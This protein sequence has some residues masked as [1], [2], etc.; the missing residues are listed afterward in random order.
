MIEYLE[1]HIFKERYPL[2]KYINGGGQANVYA[3][4]EKYAVKQ[5]HL[6]GILELL[7]ELN[8]SVLLDHPCILKPFAWTFDIR[9]YIAMPL[10][11]DI[12]QAYRDKLISIEEIVSDTLSAITYIFK[13]KIVHYDIKT[14]NILYHEGKATII[15]MGLSTVCKVE[16]RIQRDIFA[17]ARCYYEL[18]TSDYR[19]SKFETGITHVDWFLDKAYMDKPLEEILASI[20]KQLIVRRY[21]GK[22]PSQKIVTKIYHFTDKFNLKSITVNLIE[23]L[24]SRCIRENIDMKLL[25]AMCI[26]IATTIHEDVQFA[27]TQLIDKDVTLNDC[28]QMI[29]DIMRICECKILILPS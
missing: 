25:E 4:G 12:T 9:G 26:K 22:I 1:P 14:S 27:Y 15:D 28:Y 11:Q 10:G 2:G 5:F 17:L 21:T 19:L 7:T 13:L 3:S 23:T 20:P 18:I 16:D 29:A 8:Y 6:N 24:M